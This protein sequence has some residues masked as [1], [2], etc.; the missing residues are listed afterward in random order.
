MIRVRVSAYSTSGKC[1][2]K[3]TVDPERSVGERPRPA[4]RTPLIIIRTRNSSRLKG[5]AYEQQRSTSRRPSSML[6]GNSDIARAIVAQLCRRPAL[7]TVVLACRSPDDSRHRRLRRACGGRNAV[8]VRC[9]GPFALHAP[10]VDA[11]VAAAHGDLDVVIQAFGQLGG[12]E[13]ARPIRTPLAELA[14]GQLRRRGQLRPGGRGASCCRQG[15]G[16]SRCAVECCRGAYSGLELCLR[17]DQG[18]PGCL[19]DGAWPFARRMWC[20]R[21][22]GA[23]WLCSLVYDRGHG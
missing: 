3:R 12:P 6:G 14:D 20:S 4:P 16:D 5:D 21:A 15:H 2:S 13:A 17:V 8:G 22:D 10:M 1:N 11:V 9:D 18:R 19:R 7:K 23:P